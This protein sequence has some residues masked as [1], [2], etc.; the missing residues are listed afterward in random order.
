MLDTIKLRYHGILDFK[1]DALSLVQKQEQGLDNA[2]VPAHH[3]LYKAIL[4]SQK[5]NLVNL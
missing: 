5:K 3:Q 2:C 1:N 4:K